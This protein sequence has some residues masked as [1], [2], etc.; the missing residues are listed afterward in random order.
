MREYKNKFIFGSRIYGY[1]RH[2][3]YRLAYTNGNRKFTPRRINLCEM[4][5]KL[6][7]VLGEKRL[8]RTKKQIEDLKPNNNN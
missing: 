6:G 4:R 8:F 7:Y 5:G 2:E 1:Y 3:L